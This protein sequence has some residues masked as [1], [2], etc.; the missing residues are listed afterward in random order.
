MATEKQIQKVLTEFNENWEL[1][2]QIVDVLG[3]KP[4]PE[5]L[6]EIVDYA[7]RMKPAALKDRASK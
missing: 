3:L 1:A 6:T 5:R 7:M 4:D 2:L